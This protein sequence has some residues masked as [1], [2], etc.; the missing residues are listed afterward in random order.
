MV[1]WTDVTPGSMVDR[2]RRGHWVRWGL[3]GVRCVSAMAHRSS[4]EVAEGDEGDEAVLAGC[5]LEHD[6]W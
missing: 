3:A 6:R 4:L 2:G 5:S 1:R